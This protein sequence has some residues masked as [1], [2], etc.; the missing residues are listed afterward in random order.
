MAFLS[1]LI[2]SHK[3]HVR[4]AVTHIITRSVGRLAGLVVDM[5]CTSMIDVANEFGVPSYVFFTSSAAFLGLMFHLQSLQDDQK[6][7]ITDFKD[8]ALEA[9]LFVPSFSNPVPAKVLPSVVLDKE[10]GGC[11]MFLANARRFRETK[12]IMINTFAELESHAIKSLS[13]SAS[14]SAAADG[15]TTPPVHPVGPILSMIKEEG[16]A[17]AMM[18]MRWLDYQPPS[19]VVFLCFGSMGSFSEEQVKEI[20]RALESSGHRF[21]WSLRRPPPKGSKIELPQ[22]YS[23]PEE[24]LPEGFSERMG[25]VIGWAPQVAV[26]S[27]PAVGGFVSHCGW[28][29]MLESIWCGVPVATWPL[30][31]EQQMNAFQMVRELGMAVE[32]KLEYRRDFYGVIRAEEIESAIRKVMMMN[33]DAGEIRNKVKE[34]K[35]KSRVAM[36]EGGSSYTSLGRMIEDVIA[37]HSHS[38][39]TPL[40]I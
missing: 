40:T 23:N 32:I 25:K 36:M 22:D 28:N 33:G 8:S 15:T 38:N 19:S 35:E 37:A 7:D 24:V 27:H 5:F 18:I 39:S 26:L 2:N 31:A 4:D 34:M 10:G 29:S 16:D 21:L 3:T 17:N 1:V 12:G 9:K 20:A 13:A 30:Y 11:A 14:A 6:Q